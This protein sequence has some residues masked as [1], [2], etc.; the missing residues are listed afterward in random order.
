MSSGHLYAALHALAGVQVIPGTETR[1]EVQLRF[2]VRIQPG[3]PTQRWLGVVDQLLTAADAQL[4][5]G[6]PAWTVDISKQY[7]RRP[8][9]KYGW[10]LIFQGQGLD[11]HLHALATSLRPI[12]V[13]SRELDEIPLY[14]SPSRSKTAGPM[15]TVALGPAAVRS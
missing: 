11:P 4:A 5:S 12:Q 10:R 1:T 9:L 7:F 13:R 14:G 3:A 2:M 6:K 8:H 15:G